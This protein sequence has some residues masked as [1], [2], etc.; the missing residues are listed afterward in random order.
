MVDTQIR[1]SDVTKFPI[2]AA[3][4]DVPREAFVPPAAR[5]VAYM[6]APVN[7]APGREMMEARTLAKLL[8]ALDIQ[9][10]DQV[11]V[12][13]G[14]MG[15]S[16]AVLSR[17]A[18]SVVMV[19]E[20]ETLAAEAE[21]ALAGMDIV[22]AV[23]L[24][25]T[26]SEGAAKAGPFDVI[27]IDGGVERLPA[28]LIEQLTEEGR[29]AAIF[30]DGALGEARIGQKVDGHMSWRFVFNATSPVLPGFAAVRE[31]QL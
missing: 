29:M 7:L 18:D 25:G 10:E 1:P 3:M 17:M 20:H 26:L 6:A 12:I 9:V 14:G 24:Q 4:L 27:L 2:I 8:D 16:A 21:A 5:P 13:G 28:S 15:Y 31:F 30:Q 23:V 22:N 11:L 19:E